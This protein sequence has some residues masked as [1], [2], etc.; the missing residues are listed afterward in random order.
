MMNAARGPVWHRKQ[1]KQGVIPD[2]LRNLD[3]EATWSHSLADGWIYG[4]GTFCLASHE[5][6]VLGLFVWML[7]SAH[8]AKRLADE[9]I[10]Y[11]GLV[12]TV[13]MDSKADDQ[14][15]YFGLKDN[16]RIRLITRPCRGKH[17]SAARKKMIREM[18]TR[19]NR[20]IFRQ[21]ST[22]IEPMQ[23]L[24]KQLFDLEQCWMRGNENNRW[25]FATMGVTVQMAQ[26][27]A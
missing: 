17:K 20:K 1:K 10:P 7:N 5:I 27:I 15:L 26:R 13:C 3:R 22:M 23:R 2:G 18:W 14:K 25:L 19:A 8:E 6:P 12:E 16:H 21:R 4:H 9:I 11:T 24:V